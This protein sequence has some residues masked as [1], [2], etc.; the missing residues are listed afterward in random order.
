MPHRAEHIPSVD[1]GSYPV[2]E[3]CSVRPLVDGVPAFERICEAVEAAHASVFVTVAFLERGFEMPG[4]RGSVFDV[5]DRAAKRGLDVRVIFW[6]SPEQEKEA[7]DIHFH[8]TGAQRERLHP[9]SFAARW[10]RLPGESCQHQKSWLVDAGLAGEIAFVGGINLECASVAERQHP[11]T[12]HGSTHDVYLELGGPAAT[13]VHHNFVQRWNEASDREHDDGHWPERRDAGAL[14]FP[15]ALSPV[16]GDA[17]VQ[18]TRTVAERRYTDGT[19]AVGGKPFAIH[20]GEFSIYDQYIKAIDSA[21]RTIY[22]EDQAIGSPKVAG[23]LKAA[24]DRGVH[25]IFTV[26]GDCH[27]AYAS[28]RKI[29]ATKPFFDLVASLDASPRFT[30]AAIA[31]NDITGNTLTSNNEGAGSYQEIYVH[32][33]IMLVDDAWATIGSTNTADRSFL[34]DTELNASVWHGDFTRDLRRDLFL[35]HLGIETHG[36]DVAAFETFQ[37]RARKNAYRKLAGERL[38]YFAY[39]LDPKLYGLAAPKRWN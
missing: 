32:A 2:R 38:P 23:H 13:D 35:E 36:D 29:A 11:V 27:P 6:R 24:L 7:P 39:Q 10:D 26:P 30:L 31:S 33:K 17:R 19:P 4:G 18:I 20:A 8:G 12:P 21:R 9:C 16:Q 3:G 34:G 37:A 5:L 1:C 25:V 22:L 28:A 15:T 14:L